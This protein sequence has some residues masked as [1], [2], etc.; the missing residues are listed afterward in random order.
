MDKNFTT[1]SLIFT[2]IIKD[3]RKW[4]KVI[5]LTAI[6][7]PLWFVSNTTNQHNTPGYA[8]LILS[9][10]HKSFFLDSRNVTT[11]R[12]WNMKLNLNFID[13]IHTRKKTVLRTVKSNFL[14]KNCV[15]QTNMLPNIFLIFIIFFF[16]YTIYMKCLHVGFLNCLSDIFFVNDVFDSC[17]QNKLASWCWIKQC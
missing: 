11:G 7:L 6:F 15:L 17:Q 2:F 3:L 4:I 13:C 1:P 5:T 10:L 14:E 12:H 9:A 16:I 8:F